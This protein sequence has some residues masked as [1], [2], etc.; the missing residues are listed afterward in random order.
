MEVYAFKKQG[1]VKDIILFPADKITSIELCYEP[2]SHQNVKTLLKFPN[3][4]IN[5]I[6]VEL[7]IENLS[8]IITVLN[9]TKILDTP[10]TMPN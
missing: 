3:I 1:T 5:N 6:L 4:K 2:Q 8:K 9:H 10:F 7:S